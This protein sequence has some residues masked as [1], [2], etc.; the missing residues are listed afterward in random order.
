M[1]KKNIL[2]INGIPDN[3]KVK[4]NKVKKDGGVIWS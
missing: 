3:H 1:S 2:F 4:V